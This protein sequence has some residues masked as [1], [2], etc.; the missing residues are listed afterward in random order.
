MSDRIA[1]DSA[2]LCVS[3]NIHIF[4]CKDAEKVRQRRF[5]VTLPPHL[6]AGSHKRG[7]LYSS[8]RSS[9]YGP[10]RGEVHVGA[11]GWAGE[12]SSLFEHPGRIPAVTPPG[13]CESYCSHQ[14]SF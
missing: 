1:D 11:P 9:R 14:P 12:I 5:P 2:K 10:G 4:T 8:R 13:T 7:A 3:I 6:L